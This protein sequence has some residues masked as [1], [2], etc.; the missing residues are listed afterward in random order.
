[1]LLPM[2]VGQNGHHITPMK[3]IV[4]SCFL[5]MFELTIS[6]PSRRIFRPDNAFDNAF[7]TIFFL[8]TKDLHS[9][10]VL[11]LGAVPWETTEN[12]D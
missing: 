12:F 5:L 8:C 9:K 1:M 7:S 3:Q 11:F 10:T 2:P 4:Y 6:S